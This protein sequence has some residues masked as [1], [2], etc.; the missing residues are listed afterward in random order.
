MIGISNSKTIYGA[1]MNGI[2]YDS[3]K[4]DGLKNFT[5]SLSF[6]FHMN[7]KVFYSLISSPLIRVQFTD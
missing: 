2:Y 6:S 1:I 4:I 7:V 5:Q 3:N